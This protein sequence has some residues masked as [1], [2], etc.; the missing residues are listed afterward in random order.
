MEPYSL[1]ITPHMTYGQIRRY[2]ESLPVTVC[3]AQL[4]ENVQGV[5]NGMLSTIIIDR[6]MT[7][8][9]K[10]CALTHEL[11][12][13]AHGDDSCN[14]IMGARME[15]RTRRE[16]AALLI[17]RIEYATL[18]NIYEGEAYPMAVELNVTE[19]VLK[20]YRE[21]IL[22]QRIKPSAL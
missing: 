12:H 4:P 17:P 2:A 19:Q 1:A 14:G 6:A 16:T 3:S 5:F 7:Y 8:T 15:Q 22:A 11:V 9:M 18:E 10:R 20:D 21:L 13:W